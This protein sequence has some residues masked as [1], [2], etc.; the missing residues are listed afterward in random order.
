MNGARLL[1][2]RWSLLAGIVFVLA[3]F[4][5][6]GGA[7]AQERGQDGKGA[8][9]AGALDAAERLAED[10][11]AAEQ[12]EA[13]V[14]EPE[15][16][17]KQAA[18][19]TVNI[20]QLARDGGP[21][22]YPILLMSLMVVCFAVER[23]IG[24]RRRNVIP[25]VLVRQLGELSG[26][27]NGFDPRQAYRFCQQHPSSLATVLRSML[28]KVGRPHSELEHAVAE[29]SQREA[30]RLYKNVRPLELAVSVTPLIGLLGTVQGMIMAFYTTANADTSVNRAEQ[31]AGGIY[32][33]LVT[34][35]AGL[36]VAIPAAMLAHWFEGRIQSLFRDVDE[37]VQG[38]LP[39][40]ERY[41]GKLRVSRQAGTDPRAGEKP[42]GEPRE[43]AA[44]AAGGPL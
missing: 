13:R 11:L 23:L 7:G 39:Q 8:A 30:S 41:E 1:A 14:D 10:A 6:A 12:S 17:D 36:C 20:L 18:V 42:P 19:P 21:L 33:A 3:A 24:L 27:P 28:L 44:S 2:G 26:K 4:C 22:M 15:A 16:V 35:F 38:L 25:P 9:A 29:A 5:M 37:L 43:P 31:L 40:L 34:T 32:V